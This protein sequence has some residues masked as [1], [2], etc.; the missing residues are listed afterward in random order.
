MPQDNGVLIDYYR[1]IS[2][3]I[4]KDG[5]TGW[6]TVGKS[7]QTEVPNRGTVSYTL[8]NLYQNSYYNISVE[9]HNEIGFSPKDF[10]LIR[11]KPGENDPGSISVPEP[12]SHLYYDHDLV[13]P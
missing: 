10:I 1:I 2:A 11:T 3:L 13:N 7:Q 8:E 6:T 5:E 4:R 12:T 9:A